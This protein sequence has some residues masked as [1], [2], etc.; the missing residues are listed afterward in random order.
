MSRVK[1]YLTYIILAT[2]PIMSI[3]DLT[4]TLKFNLAL[5]DIFVL[6]LGL[7]WILDI[8]NFKLK[9]DYPYFWYF[10]SIISIFLIS[11]IYNLNSDT[12][13]G[14]VN[15]IISEGIKF[16]ISAVYLFIGYNSCKDKDELKY[17]ANSWLIGLWIF[18]IYGLYS[19]ISVFLGKT[20]WSFNIVLGNHSRFIGTITD[21]NAAA[22]YMSISFFIVIWIKNYIV[23]SKKYSIFLNITNT[24]VFLC[25]MLT[26]SRGGILGFVASLL[27]YILLNIKT[28]LKYIYMIPILICLGL[29]IFYVDTVK[30]KNQFV[31][32]FVS[33]SQDVTEQEG[34]FDVRL[35]LSLSAIDMGMDN[36]IL[37][38]GRGNFALNSKQYL[39]DNGADFEHQRNLYEGMVAHNTLAG[40]FAEMGAIGLIAFISI[41]AII[42]YKLFKSNNL[43]LNFKILFISIWIAVFIQS[44]SISL[45]NSRVLWLILGMFLIIFDR[46]LKVEFNNIAVFKNFNFRYKLIFAISG[47]VLSLVLYNLVSYRYIYDSIDISNSNLSLEYTATQSGQYI[48][49]YYIDTK[50]STD[51]SKNSVVYIKNRDTDNIIENVEYSKAVGYANI[52]FDLDRHTDLEFCFVGQDSTKIKDIKVIKPDNTLD[53]LLN[54]YPLLSNKAFDKLKAESKLID[55]ES[56]NSA[57]KNYIQTGILD[58]N[59]TVDLGNKVRYKGVEIVQLDEKNIQFDFNFECLGKMQ[60]DYIMWM[61]LGTDDINLILDNQKPS[62][63]INCDHK[64]EIPMSQWEIGK[65]YNHR[66]TVKLEKGNYRCSFGFWLNANEDRPVVRLYNEGN[67][68]GIDLGWFTVK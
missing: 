41:F 16:I 31:N 38:V 26:M 36:P 55:L 11:N 23:H 28:F 53:V 34:M 43:N 2:F 8:R 44:M 56:L 48:F 54:R 1:S 7:V 62:G 60:Y 17:I 39:L 12:V 3:V 10:L 35:N 58:E 21:P 57:N 40:I 29:S 64:M 4:D 15:G 49:R 20:Y 65:E 19:Q 25:I 59:D 61:H 51:E 47:I 52:Y 68:A 37:G 14:G 13:S 63:F 46:D 18:I 66:Y 9:R 50:K 33:R 5:S 45:E 32:N 42:A 67:K 22:L 6:I 27:V 24:F 30:F